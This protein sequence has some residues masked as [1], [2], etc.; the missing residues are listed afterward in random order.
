[1]GGGVTM[2]DITYR[3]GGDD[4]SMSTLAISGCDDIRDNVLALAEV[5]PLLCAEF[6][7]KLLLVRAGVCVCL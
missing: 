1:M 4:G 5:N 3:S 2:E 7:T 6:Q